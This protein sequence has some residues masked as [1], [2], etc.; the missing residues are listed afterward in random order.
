MATFESGFVDFFF[1]SLS[2]YTLIPTQ[3]LRDI[4]SS[5]M[6]VH[7]PSA[8]RRVVFSP[9]L[10]NPLFVLVGMDNGTLHRSVLSVSFH[11][12]FYL[13]IYQIPHFP[14]LSCLGGILRWANVVYLIVYLSLIQP[15]SPLLIGIAGM[16]NHNTR[17]LFRFP[18]ILLM[19][20]RGIH[21]DGLLV[22][23]WT[24]VSK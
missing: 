15:L 4:Q 5:V 16:N 3:D 19:S 11:L 10:W 18:D 2:P 24:V 14:P 12:S 1:L 9:C 13:S 6:R 17:M 21:L 20:I 22:L 23:V 8:V 7:N